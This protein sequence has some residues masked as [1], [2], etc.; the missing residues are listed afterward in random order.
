MNGREMLVLRQAAR[1]EEK[2]L[3]IERREAIRPLRDMLE[4]TQFSVRLPWVGSRKVL[5]MWGTHSRSIAWED[6][7]DRSVVGRLQTEI[8]EDAEV[9]LSAA[10]RGVV[11]T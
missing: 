7:A 4:E 5:I 9:W 1:R 8:L 2:V 10:W 3:K 6:C 11:T